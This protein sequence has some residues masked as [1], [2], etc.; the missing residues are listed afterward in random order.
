MAQLTSQELANL[1][2]MKFCTGSPNCVVCGALHTEGVHQKCPAKN[3]VIVQPQI[4]EIPEEEREKLLGD[5]MKEYFEKQGW[6]ALYEKAREEFG[7]PPGCEGCDKRKDWLNW[8]H[9]GVR[10]WLS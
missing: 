5:W 3:F 7:L 1:T 10:K 8:V 9:M 2:G 6:T 4:I